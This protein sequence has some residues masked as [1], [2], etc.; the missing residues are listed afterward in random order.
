MQSADIECIR[1]GNIINGNFSETSRWRYFIEFGARE[2][3][4]WRCMQS[5][6]SS[7]QGC[8]GVP[9]KLKGGG[10][11]QFKAVRSPPKIK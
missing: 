7:T 3:G 11:A 10:R 2:V 5:A 1:S 8:R 4:R 6:E 9:R